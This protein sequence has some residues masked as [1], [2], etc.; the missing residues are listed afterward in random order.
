MEGHRGRADDEHPEEPSGGHH[1]GYGVRAVI[2]KG[3][4]RQDAGAGPGRVSS[5]RWWAAQFRPAITP[6]RRVAAEFGTPEAMWHLTPDFA[7]VT[8]GRP[9]KQPLRHTTWKRLRGF[10]RRRAGQSNQGVQRS[11]E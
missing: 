7:I 3:D 9:R 6:W 11:Q 5:T 4:G 1:Q 8:M 2:G 10:E